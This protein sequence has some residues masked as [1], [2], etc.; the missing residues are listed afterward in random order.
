MDILKK[1]KTITGNRTWKFTDGPD[2]G[3]GTDYWFADDADNEAY[4]NNDQGY[5]TI[6][7]NGQ[8][9]WNNEHEFV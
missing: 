5:I 1:L 4:A 3:M 7:V 2:S 9:I 6:S 8:P